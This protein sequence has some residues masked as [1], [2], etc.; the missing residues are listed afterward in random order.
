MNGGNLVQ[1]VNTWAVS[2][3]RYSA[4]FVRW[5]KGMLQ[6]IDKKARKLFTIYRGLPP[7]SDVDRFHIHRKDGGRAFA[8]EDC[9]EFAIRGLEVYFC[10]NEER[11]IRAAC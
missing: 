5:R 9:L 1:G 4:A 6:S 2:F 3:L 10:G 8:I 11:L 7:K